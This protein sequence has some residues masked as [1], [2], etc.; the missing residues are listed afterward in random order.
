MLLAV[1]VHSILNT[2]YVGVMHFSRR[3]KV[4]PAQIQDIQAVMLENLHASRGAAGG[5]WHLN[6]TRVQP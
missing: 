2:A 5:R 3:N 4:V 1:I 6:H